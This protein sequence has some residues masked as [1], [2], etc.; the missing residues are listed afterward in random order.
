MKAW[1]KRVRWSDLRPSDRFLDCGLNIFLRLGFD[2]GESRIVCF[3]KKSTDEPIGREQET[4]TECKEVAMLVD[5]VE[6]A[7]SPERVIA[8]F[9][10]FESIDRLGSFLKHSLCFSCLLGFVFN[11]SLCDRRLDSPKL[12]RR[13]RDNWCAL[14]ANLDKLTCQVVKSS[15]KIMD[16]VSSRGDGIK[17]QSGDLLQISG[18]VN[19]YGMGRDTR[20]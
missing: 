13:E 4:L 5:I 11:E 2:S 16:D 14:H 10:W 19:G 7:N 18:M 12:L 15:P 6:L 9:V 3:G 8:T 20:V 1:E 17:R